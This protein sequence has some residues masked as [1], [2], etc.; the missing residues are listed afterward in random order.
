MPCDDYWVATL[1]TACGCTKQIAISALQEYIDVPCFDP[2]PVSWGV[3]SEPDPMPIRKRTF[4]IERV[5]GRFATYIEDDTTVTDYCEPLAILPEP[6]RPWW[7]KV[8]TRFAK[9]KNG[10][11]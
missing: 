6:A 8:L 11:S 5:T 4:K 3:A 7:K 9:Y 2:V 1:K 10:R